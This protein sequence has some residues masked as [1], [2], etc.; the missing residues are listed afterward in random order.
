MFFYKRLRYLL[1][2]T[3]LS[4]LTACA[5]TGSTV[6]GYSHIDG[7]ARVKIELLEPRVKIGEWLV[8]RYT[9]DR[10]GFVNV[11]VVNSSGRTTQLVQNKRVK[12]G[13]T[14]RFPATEDRFDIKIDGPVGTERLILVYSKQ[15]FN[16]ILATERKG[17]QSPAMLTLSSSQLL[18][19]LNESL[20]ALTY[21]QWARS[22]ATL[23]VN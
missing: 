14:N 21:N 22:D 16:P 8:F 10:A 12:G 1:V 3:T 2:V 23:A 9:T 17:V 6:G 5:S 4:L 18:H 7:K 15:P 20:S 13:G 11:F 19:R